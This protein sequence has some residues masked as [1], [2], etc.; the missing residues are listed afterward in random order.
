MLLTSERGAAGWSMMNACG[1]CTLVCW[2]VFGSLISIG[3]KCPC[4]TLS[5]DEPHA[6]KGVVTCGYQITPKLQQL[7]I[8]YSLSLH[9]IATL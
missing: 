2:G 6:L 1:M 5:L 4:C 8:S 3:W 7:Y 9:L